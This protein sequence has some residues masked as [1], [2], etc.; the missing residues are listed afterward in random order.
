M[1]IAQ[2]WVE[3]ANKKQSFIR[4][5]EQYSKWTLP[6]LFAPD[7]ISDSDRVPSIEKSYG[8]IG[9]QCVNHVS[10][11]LA[12]V[13]FPSNRPFFRAKLGDKTRALAE[14]NGVG[15]ADLDAALGK[16]EMDS[17]QTTHVAKHRASVAES[18]KH[19]VVTGNVCQFYNTDPVDGGLVPVVYTLKN[20][21]V[22][23]GFTGVVLE[24]I[25]R[26]TKLMGSLDGKVKDVLKQHGHNDDNAE[27][28]LYTHIK[29]DPKRGLY[30]VK[31]AVE[32][33]DLEGESLVA[34]HA[35]PWITLTWNRL[36]GEH[37]GRG[38]VED[39][40]NDFNAYQT[41]TRSQSLMVSMM[42]DV[43]RLMS[44]QCSIDPIEFDSAE[45]GT[46][47]VAEPGDIHYAEMSGKQFDMAALT[48]KINQ[49][50]QRLSSAFM[51]TSASVRQAERVT[52]EEIRMQI[53][54][55]ETS[56]GG[57]YS[58]LA[59]EW[60]LPLARLLLRA[61]GID[62]KLDITP[63]I[64]TGMDAMSRNAETDAVYMVFNDLAMLANLGP[65]ARWVDEGK[66]LTFCCSNRGVDA[67]KMFRSAAEVQQMDMQQQ[68]QQ[69]A[70]QE[71]QQNARLTEAA[72]KEM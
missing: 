4:R 59:A 11:R 26:D 67:T 62:P 1:T 61:S 2:R 45:P 70:M 41:Y 3:L 17:M 36:E 8:S 7:S 15:T 58:K 18:L 38:L 53:R 39:Y 29:F 28:A 55:L 57:V 63:L 27:L 51:L 13:L 49:I 66:Y 21:S 43:K 19:L 34:P 10:N 37:Y 68:Q 25:T 12:E 30:S 65:M 72:M 24:L 71:E 42:A 20:F 46:T 64:I 35:L 52:A 50:E 14:A 33:C 6:W 31:Q 9:A 54:E 44:G 60:Q 56:L 69:A 40:E 47:F 48:S 5:C 22:V 23:R 32:E 16:I